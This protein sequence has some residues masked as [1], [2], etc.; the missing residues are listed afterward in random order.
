M[1]K[2]CMYGALIFLVIIIC[3]VLFYFLFG[4]GVF[5]SD[6]SNESGGE[7]HQNVSDAY[8]G[9]FFELLLNTSKKNE[10]NDDDLINSNES[11]FDK[12]DSL[13][14]NKP[15]ETFFK[16]PNPPQMPSIQGSN[17]E[18]THL[19]KIHVIGKTEKPHADHLDQMGSIHDRVHDHSLFRPIFDISRHQLYRN[20]I[21]DFE[22]KTKLHRQENCPNFT[23]IKSP[24]GMPFI[25][26]NIP[27]KVCS[28][29]CIRDQC[30]EFK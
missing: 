10:E 16:Y 17:K 8:N 21:D 5:R 29:T 18:S 4:T 30:F 2:L 7:D 15:K 1:K 11:L 23:N 14:L 24:I 6:K 25:Q 12:H 19:P 9:S 28:H 26:A 13:L 27:E 3:C 22:T 20:P